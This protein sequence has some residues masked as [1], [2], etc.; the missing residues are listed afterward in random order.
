M[1]TVRV[2]P[3]AFRSSNGTLAHLP[4]GEGLTKTKTDCL[5]DPGFSFKIYVE[6]E[7][8]ITKKSSFS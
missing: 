3:K 7:E 1:M 4:R 8:K 2:E 5:A 6:I